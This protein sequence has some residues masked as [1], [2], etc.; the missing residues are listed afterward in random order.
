M[1][2]VFGKP[3]EAMANGN[4]DCAFAAVTQSRWAG[5]DLDKLGIGQAEA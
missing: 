5:H 2:P 1:R 3:R 4:R